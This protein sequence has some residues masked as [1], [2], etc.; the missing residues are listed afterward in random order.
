M[1]QLMLICIFALTACANVAKKPIQYREIEVVK[2]RNKLLLGDDWNNINVTQERE[3]KPIN[4]P[5]FDWFFD[6]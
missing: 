1:K 6:K 2:P 4:K 5:R 3:I